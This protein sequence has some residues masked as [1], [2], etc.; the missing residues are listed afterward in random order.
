MNDDLSPD[1]QLSSLEAHLAAHSPFT[2]ASEKERILYACAFAAGQKT[3]SRTLRYWKMAAGA[4]SFLVVGSV[5]PHLRAVQIPAH[6]PS[7]SS[8]PSEAPSSQPPT[9]QPPSRP[10]QSPPVD[11]YS[12]VQREIAINLD[13]WQVRDHGGES[14]TTQLGEF[15]QLDP[16]SRS[17]SVCSLT[18]TALEP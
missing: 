2:S 12:P 3:A 17:L 6:Q 18:R 13:A 15:A 11:S 5:I 7:E 16:H 9:S 10:P 14:L 1:P 4:L 8:R